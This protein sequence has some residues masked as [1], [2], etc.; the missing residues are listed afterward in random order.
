MEFKYYLSGIGWATC[1]VEIN[2]QKLEFTA[3]YLTNCLDDFLKSLMYLNLYCVPKD[4]I[5]EKTECEWEGEPEGIVWSFELKENHILF[6]EAVYYED[7][8]NKDNPQTLI[9]TEYPYDDFLRIILMELDALIKRHGIIGYREQWNDCDFTLSTFLKL[10]HYI[11][12]KLKYPV[13]EVAGEFDEETRSNLK[14][15]LELLLQEIK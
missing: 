15:D 5:K 12:N 8:Y 2:A 13:K 11:I 4:E 10:K 6:I 9:N 7:L 1:I 14:Y 3:S